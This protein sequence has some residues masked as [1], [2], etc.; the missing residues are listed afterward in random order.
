MASLTARID[1]LGDDLVRTVE[2]AQSQLRQ[3]H[4]DVLRAFESARVQVH[5]EYSRRLDETDQALQEAGEE[6][7]RMYEPAADR[8]NDVVTLNVG[9][10]PY[11]VK[12]ETLCMCQG[13]FAADLFSGRWDG[14]L[15]RDGQG[16]VFLDLDP[17]VFE[18]VL[19]WLRDRKIETP[20]RPA[21]APVVAPEDLMHFQAVVDYFGFREYLDVSGLSPDG[22]AARC[23]A[24]LAAARGAGARSREARVA[25]VR[26][27]GQPGG[28]LEA[29]GS[30]FASFRAGPGAAASLGGR[31]GGGAPAEVVP[32]PLAAS[33]RS[34][35][36]SRRY[37]HPFARAGGESGAEPGV[38]AIA[39]TRAQAGAAAVRATRGYQSGLHY[40]EV[41]VR[42]ASD[43][44]YVGFVDSDWGALCQPIGRAAHSWG[45]A[46]N[47]AVYASQGELDMLPLGYNEGSVVGVLLQLDV[48]L[49]RRSASIFID[50]R[51]F[52]DVFSA[53]PDTLYPAVSNMHSPAEYAIVCDLMAPVEDDDAALADVSAG[54]AASPP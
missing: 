4:G 8:R 52:N 29:A 7:A 45:V 6:H 24:T 54:E 2:D 51:R 14:K 17:D 34:V 3:E 48:P 27:P 47:G 35:G 44:S 5:S 40:W 32:R 25:D 15:Q 9:G 41:H 18:L 23:P 26:A 53:L 13:S 21:A 39:D 50:G 43:W 10:R 22:W 28:L 31:E 46:S 42:A 11:T 1:E 20:D 16:A 30:L 33:R 12:R 36:W 38:V 49:G 19:G 37:A